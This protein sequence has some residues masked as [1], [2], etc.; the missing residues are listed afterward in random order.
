[1]LLLIKCTFTTKVAVFLCF[2]SFVFCDRLLG[3]G[4]KLN[5]IPLQQ[6]MRLHNT[7]L[8]ALERSTVPFC[9]PESFQLFSWFQLFVAQIYA[10]SFIFSPIW[11]ILPW[12]QAVFSF[13]DH[14]QCFWQRS[15]SGLFLWSCAGFHKNW[16]Q[17]VLFSHVIIKYAVTSHPFSVG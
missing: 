15:F 9:R 2:Q 11:A 7:S 3:K 4:L 5:F 13:F 14:F 12:F 16:Q 10:L 8:P 17:R 1:M 6:W